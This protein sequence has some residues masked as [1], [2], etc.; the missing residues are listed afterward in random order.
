[1][2][3][4]VLRIIQKSNDAT[5]MEEIQSDDPRGLVV[6]AGGNDLLFRLSLMSLNDPKECVGGLSKLRIEAKEREVR[7]RRRWEGRSRNRGPKDQEQRWQGE[8]EHNDER[9]EGQADDTITRAIA[10]GCQACN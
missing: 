4:R 6:D 1:M 7:K 2:S 3:G 9:E 5:K 10:E 8:K